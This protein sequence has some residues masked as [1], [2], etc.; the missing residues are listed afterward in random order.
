[1]N[2]I[3]EQEKNKIILKATLTFRGKRGETVFFTDLDAINWINKNYPDIKLGDCIDAPTK[4]I[5][6]ISKFNGTWVFNVAE[7]KHVDNNVDYVTIDNIKKSKSSNKDI[8]QRTVP[9]T[10]KKTTKKKRAAKNKTTE[11]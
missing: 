5:D 10:A 9:S 6:N 1:M 3:L 7:E 2:I 8:K 4:P 11:E